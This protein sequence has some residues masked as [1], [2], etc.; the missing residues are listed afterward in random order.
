MVGYN[1]R[2]GEI[3]STIGIEQLKKMKSYVT[4]RQN[5]AKRLDDGL[6]D[7][8]GLRTPIVKNGCTHAYYI[9]GMKLDLNKIGVSRSKLI[10]ALESEGLQGLIGGYVNVHLLPMYQKKIAYG[11]KGFPWTSDICKRKINYNKGICPIAEE[12]NE[13]T[14]IGYQMCL[15]DLSFKDVDLIIEVFKKVWDNLYEIR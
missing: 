6:K 14:F 9:Y 2:L 8:I 13:E 10:Q 4:K 1:F 11:S 12:L 5:I 7:L 15:H 3:E